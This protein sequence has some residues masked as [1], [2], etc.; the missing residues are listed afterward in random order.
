MGGLAGWF[1]LAGGAVAAPDLA[2]VQSWIEK[3]RSISGLAAEFTQERH[4]RTVNKPLVSSG[5][6][7]F[8]AAGALRWELGAP[9]RLIALRRE[10]GGVMTVLEP[11]DKVRR[12]FTPEELRDRK[13]PYA[14]LD[15]GFPTSLAE[16]EKTFRI[17][18]VETEGDRVRI[19]TQVTDSRMA[20]AVMKISFVLDAATSQLRAFEIWFRDGS[21]IINTFTRV[22]ENAAVPA[23]LLAVP[24]GEWKDV[25]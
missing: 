5:K 16:F 21:K 25:K 12:T 7:W 19:E 18:S 1:L 22:T 3:G 23:S 8:T 9:P 4:L 17:K 24:D 10:H 20:V 13:S 15:A 2:P 11:R 6:L 14:M